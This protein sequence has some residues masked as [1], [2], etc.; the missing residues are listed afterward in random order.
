MNTEF[1]NDRSEL[2]E[3]T[4]KIPLDILLDVLTIIVDEKLKYEVI[5]V[6]QNRSLVILVVFYKKS[7][8]RD[9]KIIDNLEN[10]ILDYEHIRHSENEEFNWSES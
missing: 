6:S 5:E 10:L 4:L 7:S 8:I 2:T 9:Q 3:E 1:M